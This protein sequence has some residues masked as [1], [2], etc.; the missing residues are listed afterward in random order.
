MFVCVI[1]P[2]EAVCFMTPKAGELVPQPVMSPMLVAFQRDLT[3]L[4]T[5]VREKHL[6]VLQGNFRMSRNISE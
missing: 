2:C 5:Q 3:I 6:F 1:S 4:M